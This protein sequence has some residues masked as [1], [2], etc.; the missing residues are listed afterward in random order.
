MEEVEVCVQF[1][2]SLEDGVRGRISL[3]RRK[4]HLFEDVW[5]RETVRFNK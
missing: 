1:S 3:R 5:S 2:S 4:Q